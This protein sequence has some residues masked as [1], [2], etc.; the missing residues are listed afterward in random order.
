MS[1][2]WLLPF[3]AMEF[4]VV[5]ASVP[6]ERDQWQS[7]WHLLP[8][9][10][11]DVYFLPGYL[12]AYEAEGKGEAYCAIALAEDSIWLYPFLKCPLQDTGDFQPT[13]ALCDVQT[14]YGYG[15]PV[16]N[17]QGEDTRFLQDVWEEWST[18]CIAAG[19]IGEFVRFHPLLDNRRWAPQEM[20]VFVD[21]QTVAMWLD[22]YPQAVW[23]DSY[24]RRHR[25]M[26]RKAE[27]EGCSFESLPAAGQM[28]WFAL[29]YAKTQDRLQAKDDTRFGSVYFE[30]LSRELSERAWLGIVRQSGEV[31][32]AV[33]V[34][35][36][37]AFAHSHLMSDC[38]ING[39]AGITNLVYHGIALEAARRGLC[40]LHMGGG[41]TADEKD[42]LFRFKVSLSPDQAN[43][44]L[45]TRC[46]NPEAYEHLA[47]EWEARHGP[48]P[49]GYFLFYRLRVRG[50][51]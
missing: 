10:R 46:H 33:F 27:R 19:V 25:H 7:A 40:V 28:S 22:R 43:F 11:R 6:G 45:G 20:R 49:P 47:S 21:R 30:A 9:E 23:N 44:W 4:K 34:L 5:R 17:E 14:P 38:R 36:G 16:V 31:V 32:A 15:G 51:G 24:F 1:I 37:A 2:A 13:G 8:V 35:E 29:M 26:I 3:G 48:R 42:S 12:Q 18:W 50:A 41:R 39:P